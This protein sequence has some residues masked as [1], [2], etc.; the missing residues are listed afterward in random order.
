MKSFDVRGSRIYIDER[1][2]NFSIY[3]EEVLDGPA[4]DIE[5]SLDYSHDLYKSVA[6]CLEISDACNLRCSYCFNADKSGRRMDEKTAIGCLERLFLEFPN[7]EKYS[8]DVS[9]DGEPLLNLEL[10]D[11]VA[12]YAKRKSNEID[13]EV[14]VSLV[15]N[16]TLLSEPISKHLQRKGVLFGVSLDG[17]KIN[18][19][20][21]RVDERGSGTF[22]L[23]L[24]NVQTI[25]H[26]EHVGC[27]VTIA[28]DAFPL[29]ET[30]RNLKK[31]FK[32][33]SVKPARSKEFGIDE[34]SLA[35]WAE[36]YE[37]LEAKLEEELSKGDASTLFCLLNGDDYFGKFVLRSFLN[38]KALS[39]CDAGVGRIAVSIDGEYFPCP[40]MIGGSHWIG[41]LAE[42]F[43]TEE[44]RKL[45]LRQTERK[46]CASCP[47][48]YHCGGEC[49]VEFDANSGN[50]HWMCLFKQ[51]LIL[52]AMLLEERCRAFPNGIYQEIVDFCLR[53]LGR[54]EEKTALREFR[55][56]HQ[57][58]TFTEAKELFDKENP[59]Y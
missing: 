19:D 11:V 3:E 39:R 21:Y 29:F 42:G 38:L 46:N 53:K 6:F 55:N 16:G 36:E 37:K 20:R 41:S 40:A 5:A 49:A 17:N 51:K 12:D 45:Y 54:S 50:N 1:N 57:E 35:S 23:I 48:V 22:D 26:R 2:G 27:A 7:A 14:T 15:T 4:F 56:L 58:L 24:K 33:I 34:N 52:L 44:S 28:R 32:T 9:G 31:T 8:I 30:I 13:R 25:K 43:N 59:E 10:I 18:H 47:F